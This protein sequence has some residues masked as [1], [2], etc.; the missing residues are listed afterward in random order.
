MPHTGDVTEDEFDL[1]FTGM[2]DRIDAYSAGAPNHMIN[3]EARRA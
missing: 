1:Q 2:F 3:P